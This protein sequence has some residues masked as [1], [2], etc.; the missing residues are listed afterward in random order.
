[1]YV[2]SVECKL[3]NSRQRR[4]LVESKHEA[5]AAWSVG[6]VSAY[7]RGDWSYGL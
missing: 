1:M 6:I 7:C 4:T 5:L 3:N 2:G